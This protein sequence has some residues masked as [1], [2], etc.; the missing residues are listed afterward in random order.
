M[1]FVGLNRVLHYGAPSTIEDYFQESGRAGRSGELSTSTIKWKPSDAPL[2]KDLSRP[3]HAEIAAVRHYL[4]NDKE[5]RQGT[6]ILIVQCKFLRVE[7]YCVVMYVVDN[8][9]LSIILHDY[10]HI[11]PLYYS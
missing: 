11:H 10:V 1:N 4:E 6:I 8:S 2:W 5:C 7:S 9:I 3:R